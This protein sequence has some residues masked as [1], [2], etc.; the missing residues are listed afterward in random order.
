MH[1]IDLRKLDLNLLLVFQVLMTE[2]SV[3]RAAERLG[4]TQSAISHALARLREQ[5]GD[6]LLVKTAQGMRASAYAEALALRVRPILADIQ[7]VLTPAQT[8]EPASTERIFRLALPDLAQNLFAQLLGCVQARAPRAAL[9]WTA[10]AED[11]QAEL[12]EGTLDL[13]IVPASLHLAD[14]LQSTPVGALRWACFGREGHP[15]WARW[16]TAQWAAWPHVVVRVGNRLNSPV[17]QTSAF[18]GIERRIGAWVPH[19]SAVAPLLAHSDLLATL[20]LAALVD[21]MAM[22]LLRVQALPFPIT[23]MAHVLV[24][25]VRHANDAAQIWLRTQVEAVWT[26]MLARADALDR[27]G[28]KLENQKISTDDQAHVSIAHTRRS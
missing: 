28:T 27:C 7:R 4:R 16:D 15:A 2:R 10:P 22:H 1:E 14:G 17:S 8:F 12:L 20:P 13:A 9:E 11:M 19:F 5:L 23:P 26:G 18:L 21:S 24:Q 25:S 3:T 6:P